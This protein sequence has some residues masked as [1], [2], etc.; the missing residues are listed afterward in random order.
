MDVSSGA[1]L[2]KP[3]PLLQMIV[4]GLVF[5]V[6]IYVTVRGSRANKKDGHIAPSGHDPLGLTVHLNG[7][8]GMLN[9][10]V[11]HSR[12]QLELLHQ[13]HNEIAKS[14]SR[15]AELKDAHANEMDRLRDEVR[16]IARRMGDR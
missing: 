16:A 2:L 9:L 1:D 4:G 10:L 6:G 5:L 11:E 13:M 14:N 7:A 15:L 8:I 12:Q 3:F